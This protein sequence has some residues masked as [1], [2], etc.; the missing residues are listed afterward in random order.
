MA[1]RNNIE[2][3][4]Y[5]PHREP[6][7]LVDLITKIDQQSVETTFHIPEDS[8][9]VDNGVLTE[10]GLIENA[11]QTCSAIVGQNYF[12]DTDEKVSLLGFIGGIRKL[13]IRGTPAVGK[14]LVTTACMISRMNTDEYALYLL[15][16]SVSC[17]G[18]VFLEA[19]MNLFVREMPLNKN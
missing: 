3:R 19:E 16:C 15:K 17:E 4:R 5:L 18:E 13:S 11:A 6:M 2:L 10:A 9:F 7:L 12:P 1:E 8:L 14:T